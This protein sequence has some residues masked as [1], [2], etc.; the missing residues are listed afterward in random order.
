MTESC[1]CDEAS[2]LVTDDDESSSSSDV[3]PVAP[4]FTVEVPLV[5]VVR[6]GRGLDRRSVFLYIWVMTR[7]MI[8]CSTLV[9]KY[10]LRE[11]H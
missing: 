11:M 3:S 7:A 4:L 2:E 9:N 5:A 6:R 8:S 10:H 1:V